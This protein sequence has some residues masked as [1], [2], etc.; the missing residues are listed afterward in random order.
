MAYKLQY[1]DYA[2]G[3]GEPIP[4]P[5]GPKGDTGPPGAKGDPGTSGVSPGLGLINVTEHGAKGDGFTDDTAAIQAVLTT[6][7][8]KGVVFIPNTGSPYMTKG[9]TVPSGTDMLLF[10]T[11]RSLPFPAA[12]GYMLHLFGNRDITIRG[13]GT[14]DCNGSVATGPDGVQA[15]IVTTSGARNIHISEITIKDSAAWNLNICGASHVIVNGVSL[16]DGNN[17]NEFAVGCDDCWI[18]NSLIH[19]PD[20][21]GGFAF[22]GGVTNSGAIGNTIRNA[23]LV[24]GVGQHGLYLLA[25]GPTGSPTA[26]GCSNIVMADNIIYNTGACGIFCDVHVAAF[27]KGVIISNNRC[28]ENC[29]IGGDSAGIHVGNCENVTVIG[30]H[31]TRNKGILGIAI[32]GN[33]GGG[34][35][36]VSVCGNHI[37]DPAYGSTGGIGIYVDQVSNL[38]VSGNYTL[39]LTGSMNSSIG[40]TAGVNNVFVGNFFGAPMNVTLQSDTITANA[41][42]GNLYSFGPDTVLQVVA[43]MQVTNVAQQARWYVGRET[44]ESGGD[45]GSDFSIIGVRDNASLYPALGINRA[46]GKVTVRTLNASSLPT[47]ATGL[48]AGDV[49]RN[50]TV[51]NI[52]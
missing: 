44:P 10:G 42:G 22:Y 43:P 38:L 3:G 14:I 36:G 30:N 48:I 2:T 9:L 21:D 17:S 7:A 20:G 52:V 37:T 27:H 47:S 6:Y 12:F 49:W 51:L 31:V 35:G 26:A 1:S 39:N 46:S 25:D 19:G 8:G 11:L 45:T 13:H 34:L 24:G 32:V 15:G 40:G 5:P 4:G 50:G 33:P 23:G 28:Y 18:T 41:L 16:L 29:Q